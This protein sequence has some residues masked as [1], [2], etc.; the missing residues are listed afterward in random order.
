MD[1]STV[2]NKTREYFEQDFSQ[3]LELTNRIRQALKNGDK[4][5]TKDLNIGGILDF[6]KN[7]TFLYITLFQ[8][9]EKLLRWGSLRDNLTDTINRNIEQIR[10]NPSFKNFSVAD[11]EKCRIMIE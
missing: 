8:A 5:E 1:F 2:N 3:V 7:L 9:G 4:V 6:D 11:N 10:K